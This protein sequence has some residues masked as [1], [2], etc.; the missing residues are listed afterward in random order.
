MLKLKALLAK[1]FKNLPYT[2][3]INHQRYM[4]LQLNSAPGLDKSNFLYKGDE[5][6]KGML[7]QSFSVFEGTY[8]IVIILFLITGFT[9]NLVEF[10][11]AARRVIEEQFP[12]S[13]VTAL[14]WYDT[15]DTSTMCT[16]T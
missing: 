3:A 6:G 7:F 8:T 5:I 14:Q 4:C 2:V 12:N 1:N 11:Q 13:T 10:P 15:V 9:A 16:Y